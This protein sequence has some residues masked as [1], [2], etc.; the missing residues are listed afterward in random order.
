M[1]RVPDDIAREAVAYAT[2]TASGSG[3]LNGQH[4]RQDNDR[5]TLAVH[6]EPDECGYDYEAGECEVEPEDVPA[7]LNKKIL[8]KIDANNGDLADVSEQVWKAIEGANK[9]KPKIYR[10][11]S[12]TSWI[13]KDDSHFPLLRSLDNDRMR[14]FLARIIQFT[15]LVKVGRNEKEIIV[16]PPLDVVRDVRVSPD[17]PLPILKG[18]VE[19]PVFSADGTIQIEPGYCAASQSY[20]APADKFEIP[21]VP[22]NPSA[23]D[24]SR[25]KLLLLV[26]LAGDFPFVDESDKATAL[27]AALTPFVR[28][29]IHGP[30]PIHDFEASCPGTG[31]TKLVEALMY[32]WLG[33]S[34]TAMTE[35]K[36]EEEWRKRLFAKLMTAPSAVFID[37]VRSRVDSGALASVVTAFPF[38]EDRLLGKSEIIRVPVR[39]VWLLTGNNPSFSSEMTRRT[40]RCRLDAKRDQPWLREGFKHPALIEWAKENRSQLVW[41]ALTLIQAWVANGRPPGKKT[42]GMFES[43]ARTIGGILDVI[44]VPGFLSGLNEF[45]ETAD[46][47][48]A[49][50]RAF[51]VAWWDSFGGTES[52][53]ADLYTLAIDAGIQLGEKSEQSQKVKLGQKLA[54]ARDRVFKVKL[55]PNPSK[56]RPK[57]IEI[58]L[59]ISHAGTQQRAAT[60]KIYAVSG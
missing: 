3:K 9:P 18:I 17:P 23:D 50:W 46:A 6:A 29:M 51:V 28:E 30:I 34:V 25:A 7:L 13:E 8:P 40:I 39:P 54:E 56:Q 45:Y 20:Y 43:W 36:N 24:I 21:D 55:P 57:E 35:G 4:K 33:R 14:H 16:P 15:R 27:S 22:K 32:P 26:E 47:E 52:K 2:A 19:S 37:N 60:W 42:L 59:Q 1:G 10:Y 41:A 31:K 53:A 49:A 12:I 44:E 48:G 38:W 5:P 11:G 58:N